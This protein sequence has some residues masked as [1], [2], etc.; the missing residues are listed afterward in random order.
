MRKKNY[1]RALNRE[2]INFMKTHLKGTKKHVVNVLK[3]Q[4]SNHPTKLKCSARG[5]QRVCSVRH[6]MERK[7]RLFSEL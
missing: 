7:G 2:S 3:F 6:K 1:L 4:G 5:F